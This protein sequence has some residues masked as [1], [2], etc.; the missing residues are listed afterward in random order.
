[1]AVTQLNPEFGKDGLQ[2]SLADFQH[3]HFVN[4]N[5]ILNASEN[6]GKPASQHKKV[7]APRPPYDPNHPDNKWPIMVHHS[8]HGEL[9]VGKSLVGVTN[10]TER[11]AITKENEKAMA[12]ALAGGY[13]KEPFLKPQ[14]VVNDSATEK[15]LLLRRLAEQDSMVTM[16]NE[17]L[18]KLLAMQASGGKTEA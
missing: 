11:V 14:V 3:A 1:M 9:S 7:N 8:V 13:R 12:S 10:P 16:L 2:D 5:G 4:T 17:K 18:E 15:A 6:I